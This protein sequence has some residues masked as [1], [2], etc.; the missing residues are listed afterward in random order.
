[1]NINDLLIFTFDTNQDEESL[2]RAYSGKINEGFVMGILNF[3]A[4]INPSFANYISM[5]KIDYCWNSD[6]KTMSTNFVITEDLCFNIKNHGIVAL[7]KGDKFEAVKS[8]KFDEKDIINTLEKMGFLI[9]ESL[10]NNNSNNIKTIICK[11]K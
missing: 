8:R 7:K 2:L 1:M 9:L 10:R 4:T 3:F 6:L 11:K 5:F